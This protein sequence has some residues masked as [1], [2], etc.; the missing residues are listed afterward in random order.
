MQAAIPVTAP[1]SAAQLERLRKT[2]NFHSAL[3]AVLQNQRHVATAVLRRGSVSA[4]DFEPSYL[5]KVPLAS[6]N[7]VLQILQHYGELREL[8]PSDELN[9]RYIARYAANAVSVQIALSP[10]GR[11]SAFSLHPIAGV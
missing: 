11:I 6:V 4:S 5:E 3:T 1:A 2:P 9:G 8:I 7:A 10:R